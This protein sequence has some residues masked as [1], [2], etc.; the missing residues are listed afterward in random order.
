MSDPAAP[1][2]PGAWRRLRRN[3]IAIASL[4]LLVA[5]VYFAIDGPRWFNYDPQTTTGNQFKEPSR[6][7]PFGTDINGRDVLSRVVQGA[8]ISLIVGACGAFVSFLVGTAYGMISGYFGGRTDEL[9]MRV[10]DILYG[11]PRLLLIIIAIFVFDPPLRTWLEAR[12]WT[13]MVGYS[14]IILLIITLGLNEWLSL[15]RIVRGQVLSLKQQQFI[16]AA[17]ALGQSHAKI[18]IRHLLPNLL[19]IVTVYLTLTIPA[20][21]LDESFLSFLGLGIQAPQASWGTLLSDGANVI[22]PVRSYWWLLLFPALAM[23]LT[24]VALNFLG[25]GLRDAL[26]PRQRR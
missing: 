11:I 13:G 19:G 1:A 10:L 6:Q 18:I 14:R 5:L 12:N 26:D 7:H 17:R 2:A 3:P 25:D 15:A 20:V 24:L 16:L 22:N 21:I 9:M 8:R 23:S 4:I